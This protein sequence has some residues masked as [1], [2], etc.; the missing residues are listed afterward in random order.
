MSGCGLEN[1]KYG[2]LKNEYYDGKKNHG[3]HLNDDMASL[4]LDGGAENASL[5]HC[6]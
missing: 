6:K 2:D 5:R 4:G 1:K 3:T